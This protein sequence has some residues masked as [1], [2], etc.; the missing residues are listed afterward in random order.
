MNNFYVGDSFVR[1]Q[2]NEII[3][4]G[5]S[6]RIPPKY[7]D[8]L[9]CLTERPDDV[10]PRE[11]LLERAWPDAIVVDGNLTRAIHELRKVLE[12]DASKP[13]LIQTIAKRGYLLT[14]FHSAHETEA[15]EASFDLTVAGKR[16]RP[17]ATAYW[18]VAA[19][20]ALFV[21]ATTA[22]TK[23][24]REASFPYAALTDP[25]PLTSLVGDELDPAL[26]PNGR[27]AAF[28][29]RN[30]D[31]ADTDLFVKEI[32][33][34]A[35]RLVSGDSASERYP[36]WSP[37]GSSLAFVRCG[38]GAAALHV[39]D[40]EGGSSRV[41]TTLASD[42]C[43]RASSLSWSPD[44]RRIAFV[45]AAKAGFSGIQTL[46]I[47]DGTRSSLTSPGSETTDRMPSFSPNGTRIAFVRAK[48]SGHEIREVGTAGGES[49][50]VARADFLVSGLDW[51]PDGRYIIYASNGDL[52]HV[53]V[54]RGETRKMAGSAKYDE[55][56]TLSRNGD[57]LAYVSTSL[58]VNVWTM[59]LDGSSGAEP[60]R[61]LSST[62][63]DGDPAIS[64]DGNR[65]AFISDRDGQCG[66]WIGD[67]GETHSS[68]IVSFN[69][70]CMEMASPRWSPDGGSIAYAAYTGAHTDVYA[71]NVTSRLITRLTD[72][73]AD[74]ANPSWSADG[75]HVYY[76]SDRSGT[77]KLYRVP[78]HGG[79]SAAVGDQEA[80][81]ASEDLH[82]AYIYF[83]RR[84]EGGLLR[85]KVGG[86]P[87]EVVIA[88]LHG[89]DGS[90]WRLTDRGVY[91]VHRSGASTPAIEFLDLTTGVRT[92]I[93]ELPI[94]P[95]ECL[96]ADFSP[97]G[98]WT[99]FAKVDY[100]DRDI[101][102]VGT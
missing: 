31:A 47:E 86:G 3:R 44:G 83:T 81:V 12:V 30:S 7:M 102:I 26:S 84:N 15:P 40:Y 36:A 20:A 96:R 45:D 54:T 80:F 91:Y 100:G 66:I 73:P 21:A 38:D 68:K 51:S 72:H 9:V 79:A 88:K 93:A 87:V 42:E 69:H 10:W 8:V 13:R 64:P 50:L 14:E 59:D 75:G 24:D 94:S 61:L 99:A 35:M 82:G 22:V 18:A 56:P 60:S 33:T 63:I 28:A 32:S 11:E 43:A 77:S 23:F 74:D 98:T 27:F 97:D 53:D 49:N 92:R 55:E 58:D 19:V 90:N 67:R 17:A 85:T 25:V 76:S 34:G 95:D 78:S 48:A 62:R 1:P 6:I 65:V 57:R 5:E 16:T 41:L 101:V 70:E 89:L 37:D 46:L 2:L 39:V 71:I 52:W 4:S 29:W